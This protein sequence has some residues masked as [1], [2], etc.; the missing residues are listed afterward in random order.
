V[1]G[2]VYYE[3]ITLNDEKWDGDKVKIIDS[4]VIE[5]EKMVRIYGVEEERVVIGLSMPSNGRSSMYTLLTRRV[6]HLRLIL[7]MILLRL[8]FALE[9]M[10]RWQR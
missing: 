10:K 9:Q 3:K 8:W 4:V 2:K 7:W 6:V 1:N 5:V